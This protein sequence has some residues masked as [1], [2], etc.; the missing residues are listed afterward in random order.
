MQEGRGVEQVVAILNVLQGY[1]AR[2]S[3]W[4]TGAGG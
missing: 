3:P 2:C 4:S 1:W